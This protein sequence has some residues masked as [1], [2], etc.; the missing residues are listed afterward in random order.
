MA[1]QRASLITLGSR[2]LVAAKRFYCDG[3]GWKP[4]F[5]NDEIVFYDLNG[6]LLA[7]FVDGALSEDM[8][9]SGLRPGNFAIAHNVREEREVQ[10]LIDALLAA[11]GTLLRAPDTSPI[12]GLRGYVTDP[13]E[14]AWE[15]AFNPSFR[16]EPSGKV[17][18]GI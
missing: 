10:P 13:D 15:I 1:E 5:E 12:G 3:F 6:L 16:I 8:Q 11:G 7:T 18:F 17:V 9:R 4:V 2:D 14:H